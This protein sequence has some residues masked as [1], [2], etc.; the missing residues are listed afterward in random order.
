MNKEIKHKIISLRQEMWNKID[1]I[2][3]ETEK[4]IIKLQ[5]ENGN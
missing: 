2:L 4:E 1:I 3:Q 5:E